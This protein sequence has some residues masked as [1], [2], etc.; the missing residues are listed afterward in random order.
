MIYNTTTLL[1]KI[2]TDPIP[3]TPR[4]IILTRRSCCRYFSSP[5]IYIYIIQLNCAFKYHNVAPID[6]RNPVGSVLFLQDT[7]MHLTAIPQDTRV[8]RSYGIVQCARETFARNAIIP[9]T[10][11]YTRKRLS[12]CLSFHI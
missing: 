9:V 8:L 5:S 4:K 1:K 11:S 12:V 10:E 7:S 6:T 3:P 2:M